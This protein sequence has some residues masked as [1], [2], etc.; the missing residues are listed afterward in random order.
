MRGLLLAA[1]AALALASFAGSVDVFSGPSGA[2]KT[3]M[4]V[5][6]GGGH[7]PPPALRRYHPICVSGRPC[8]NTCIARDKACHQPSIP[9]RKSG[10]Q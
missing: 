9:L 10:G 5:H 7:V 6:V 3:A 2:G 1:V 8:G 4:G